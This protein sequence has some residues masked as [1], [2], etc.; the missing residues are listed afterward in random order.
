M[1][2]G[3]RRSL[4]YVPGDSERMLQKAAACNADLLILNL[5]DGVAVD[6]K[7]EARRNVQKALQTLDFGNK[8]VIVRINSL[9]TK[10]GEED[11]AAV[12]PYG[13]DG[14]CLPK[15]EMAFD[16][17]SAGSALEHL[18]TA[19]GLPMGKIKIHVM[20]ESAGGVMR[21]MEIA[22]ASS[23]MASL[24]FG[25]ADYR[26]H[27]RCQPD[28]NRTELMFPLQMII[29]AA[30][31]AGIDAIDGPCFN[32]RNPATLREEAAQ[33]RR[34]GFDGKSALHPDQLAV[35]NEIFD[36]TPQELAWAEQVM[37]ALSEAESQGKAL[38]TL[39]G[40]LI[41]NPHRLAAQRILRGRSPRQPE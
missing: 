36:V 7:E 2:T 22:G 13:P 26:T 6:E 27:V 12:V 14:I 23:R 41:D 35:I 33:A 17:Q 25:S 5:E 8:E 10:M 24:L 39:D 21:A 38:S 16:I 32:L 1:I 15:V 19:A 30:R 28:R 4:L 40:Q 3:L 31:A 9:L 29:L 37:E 20:I 18:E 11:L 34:M